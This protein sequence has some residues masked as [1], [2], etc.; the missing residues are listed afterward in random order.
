MEAGA[1]VPANPLKV[2]DKSVSREGKIK[3]KLNKNARPNEG[4]K[5]IAKT[6]APTS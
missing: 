4:I 2:V 1:P 5:V 3:I 6:S